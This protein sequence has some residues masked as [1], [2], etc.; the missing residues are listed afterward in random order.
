MVLE[1]PGRMTLLSLIE[2]SQ[3]AVES[4]DK[5][6]RSAEKAL[7]AA[8]IA[9]S[10]AKDVLKAVSEAFV[11]ED[12]MNQS[13]MIEVKAQ[14]IGIIGITIFT[15]HGGQAGGEADTQEVDNDTGV[16][17]VSYYT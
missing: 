15:G 5:A 16:G 14:L 12:N 11:Q 13:I 8:Q 7:T 1:T 6:L 2:S 4:S 9:N 17:E 3:S 10:Q